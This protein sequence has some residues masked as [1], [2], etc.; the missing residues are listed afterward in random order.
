MPFLTFLFAD[1]LFHPLK[2]HLVIATVDKTVLLTI[3]CY[4]FLYL[5]RFWLQ[6]DLRGFQNSHKNLINELTEDSTMF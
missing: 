4:Q 3:Y 2:C 6:K 1:I 5:A